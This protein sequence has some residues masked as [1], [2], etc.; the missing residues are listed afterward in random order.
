MV[1][2]EMAQRTYDEDGKD[3]RGELDAALGVAGWGTPLGRR[4][5]IERP[6]GAPLWYVGEEEASQSFLRAMGVGLE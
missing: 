1:Y 2:A 6:E 5:M 3:H 4:Y